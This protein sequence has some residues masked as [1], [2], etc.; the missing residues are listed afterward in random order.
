MIYLTV[1]IKTIW[2]QKSFDFFFD[3]VHLLYYKSHEINPNS[4]GSYIDSPDWI[5][6][7][8]ATKN[9]ININEEIK[10]DL[11]IITKIKPFINKYNWKGINFPSKKLFGKNLRKTM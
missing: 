6:N 11:Q 7:K 9:L 2:N 4:C 1:D 5:E 10:K 8:K 3:Y